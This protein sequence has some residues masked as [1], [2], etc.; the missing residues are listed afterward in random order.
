MY[1]RHPSPTAE[2]KD[3]MAF[4]AI[5]IRHV[6]SAASYNRIMMVGQMELPTL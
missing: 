6:A 3:D 1:M 4:L 5:S 2:C